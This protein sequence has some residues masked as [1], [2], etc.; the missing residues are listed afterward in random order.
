VIIAFPIGIGL[1]GGFAIAQGIRWGKVRVSLVGAIFG[2][3]LGLFVYGSYR[4]TE[5]LLNRREAL[6]YIRQEME[7]EFGEADPVIADEVFDAILYE[8]TGEKRESL[9][10]FF[11]A[12]ALVE[13]RD[14]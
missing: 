3:L 1:I 7:A 14:D 10:Q 6:T 11:E 13:H 2:L 12:A 5:Y 9:W 4:Y 8:E